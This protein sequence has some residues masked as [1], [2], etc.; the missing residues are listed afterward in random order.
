MQLTLEDNLWWGTILHLPSWAGYQSR[1]GPYTSI[2]KPTPS[3][4]KVRLVFAPDGRGNELLTEQETQLVSWFEANEA[5]VSAAVKVAILKWCAPYTSQPI[6]NENDLKCHIGLYSI[7]IHQLVA[8]D[9]PYIGF[10]FGCN[11]EEEHGL[12]VM[13]HGTRLVDIGF[14]DTALHLWVAQKDLERT[15]S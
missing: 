12:G 6:T 2:D 5:V 3:D 9:F 7:N 10:E 14:A 4:G 11:W 13:M 8:H 15:P 1:F